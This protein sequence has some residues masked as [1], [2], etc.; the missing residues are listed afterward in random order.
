MEDQYKVFK[1]FSDF[2]SGDAARRKAIQ[3]AVA[4]DEEGGNPKDKKKKK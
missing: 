1:D 4:G 2:V 3:A